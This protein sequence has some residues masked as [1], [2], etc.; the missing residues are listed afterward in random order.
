MG[1][2]LPS[3]FMQFVLEGAADNGPSDLSDPPAASPSL[4]PCGLPFPWRSIAKAPSS[5]RRRQ[6]WQHERRRRLWVN[7]AVAYL[8]W[9]SLGRPGGGPPARCLQ[10]PV[11]SAQ[12][13]LVDGLIERFSGVCRAGDC[14][15]SFAGGIASLHDAVSTLMDDVYQGTNNQFTNPLKLN[16]FNM[17]V[18]DVGAQVLIS[19]P[20]VPEEFGMIFRSPGIFDLPDGELPL[21][22]PNMCMAVD[23]WEPIAAKL[24]DIGLI[25]LVPSDRVV[26]IGGKPV[27]AG[28]FG[29]AKKLTSSLRVIVDRRRRNSVEKRLG[30]V[31]AELALSTDMDSYRHADLQR[32]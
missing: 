7:T 24:W 26:H 32:L 22:L 1:A 30:R 3:D 14:L 12:R 27:R 13:H 23:K 25:D 9:L 4:L 16:Q 19:E 11:S 2:R 17:S 28:L 8:S 20:R 29:V 15:R 21:R 6:R 5:A 10:A 31:L 18:P